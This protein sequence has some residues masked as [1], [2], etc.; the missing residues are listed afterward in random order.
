MYRVFSCRNE[1]AG[2]QAKSSRSGCLTTIPLEITYSS[3][4]RYRCRWT[5]GFSPYRGGKTGSTVVGQ[6]F[7]IPVSSALSPFSRQARLHENPTMRVAGPDPHTRTAPT[8]TD[9]V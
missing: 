8:P 7:A 1:S 5:Q 3:V 9:T 2:F 4:A 6:H